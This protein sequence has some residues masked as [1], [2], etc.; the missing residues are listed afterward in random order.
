MHNIYGLFDDD[1][2]QQRNHLTWDALKLS[3]KTLIGYKLTGS[4][5]SM[6]MGMSVPSE[7]RP[8]FIGGKVLAVIIVVCHYYL[9]CP[10]SV[11]SLI[12]VCLS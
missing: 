7:R 11:N 5:S 2:Q 9:W 1:I 4:A 6:H 12:S 3:L 10:N 8:G